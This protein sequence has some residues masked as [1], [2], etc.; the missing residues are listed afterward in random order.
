M[1]SF[2]TRLTTVSCLSLSIFAGAASGQNITDDS[3]FYGQSPSVLPS[4]EIPGTLSWQT[5]HAKAVALVSQ[6]T[7]AERANIT[8]GYEPT[9]G[10]SGVTGTVPRLG[11]EGLCLADAGQGLRATDLVNA[12]PAGI[13]VGSSWNKALTLQRA[14]HMAAEFKRKGVH[15][16]LGPVVGPLGR[17]ALGGR[18]WE[19]FSNDPYLSGSLV[20]DTIKGIQNAGVIASVKHFI[21]NEQEVNRNPIEAGTTG[22]GIGGGG[23]GLTSDSPSNLSQTIESLSANIDDKTMH[24]L[25]LWPFADAIHAGSASVMCSYQRINNSYGC[26]NQ[27]AQN[28]LLKTELGFEGFVV[29]DWGA[30][31]AGIASAE[32]GLDMAMPDGGSFWGA[33]GS[34]LTTFVKNGSIPEA[35]LTDMATRIVAA[36]YQLGQDR[37]FPP[38]GLPLQY[39]VS[40]K[41]VNARDPASKPILLQGAIEGHVL[42]KNINKTLPFK[43]PKLL[44]LFG[45]DAVAPPRVNL[46]DDN[47]NYQFGFLS[48]SDFFWRDAFRSPFVNPGQIGPNGTLIVGGGSG[49]TAPAYISAP[50]DALQERA[51][52]DGFQLLW[53]FHST[54]PLVDQASDACLVFINAFATEGVDREGLHD[55][56]SDDIILNVASACS[57]TIVVI[58]NAG[59]RLVDTWIEHPNI[60]SVIFAHLPGQDSGRA[61]VSLLFGDE[62]PSGKMTY[63]VARNESD[64]NVAVAHPTDEF[65]FFPQDDFTEGVYIDYRDF[66]RKNITPR[67]EFGFGL[68]YT[69]FEYS[70]LSVSLVQNAST[71]RDA[72]ESPVI[73]G[74]KESLWDVI[75]TASAV[76]TNTGDVTAKEVAQLYVHIPG[77]PVRQ[78]R[79]FE[80][81]EI[82]PGESETVKFT[83]LRR[84]LSD[85]NVAEQAWVLQQGGYPVWV[86]ASSRNL[87]LSGQLTIS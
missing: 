16:L 66:D 59:I 17:V 47:S 45:Y 61:V 71:S 78:L 1:V 38:V 70:D 37:D 27:K 14:T 65:F 43:K 19:G 30:Q 64:Y 87:P 2:T 58:H 26:H 86:G 75:A 40:H 52:D 67:Y 48:N 25:Y 5:A 80:K 83:L 77:G 8:V 41:A 60:T 81:V 35:R 68:T 20:H 74:G 50:F 12:Y 18:N 28:G 6:M 51:Y 49:G 72:P 21:G 36:W 32:G 22:G 34:N 7:L 29:S 9:T 39:N 62:S 31:H 73:E 79:G 85:W 63:T 10:C 15:V 23:S 11:W 57:N 82:A 55:D 69:T 56:Y 33:D 44:S 53:D 84:D 76:V 3:Y 4:P 54:A 46:V 13:S 42:V 24:E